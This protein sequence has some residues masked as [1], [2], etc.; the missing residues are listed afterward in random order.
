MLCNGENCNKLALMRCPTCIKMNVPSNKS[1]FCSKMCYQSCWKLHKQHHILN[2]PLLEN[3][4]SPGFCTIDSKGQMVPLRMLI[5]NDA[6]QRAEISLIFSD[7]IGVDALRPFATQHNCEQNPLSLAKY[8]Y[9][10]FCY[11][12]LSIPMHDEQLLNESRFDE[13]VFNISEYSSLF[14]EMIA[15]GMLVDTGRKTIE[16]YPVVRINEI[17]KYEVLK[18]PAVKDKEDAEWVMC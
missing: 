9:D 12:I 8:W 15:C 5:Q 16:E 18:K 13:F 3:L 4:A 17:K 14:D 11:G 7:H 10:G 2:E 6:H 1:F